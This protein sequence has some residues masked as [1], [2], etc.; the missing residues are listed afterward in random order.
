MPIDGCLWQRVLNSV[1]YNAGDA[2]TERAKNGIL[3]W[4]NTNESVGNLRRTK[5]VAWNLN[6]FRR[7]MKTEGLRKSC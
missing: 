1:D 7:A 3:E 6:G 2:E 5:V 4:T